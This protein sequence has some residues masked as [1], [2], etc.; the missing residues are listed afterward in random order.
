VFDKILSTEYYHTTA[1]MSEERE[2]LQAIRAAKKWRVVIE[3]GV[4]ARIVD[5]C[6]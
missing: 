4:W 5:V 1:K 2:V 6:N 3:A